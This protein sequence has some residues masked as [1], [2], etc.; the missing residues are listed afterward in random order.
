M[1]ESAILDFK[2]SNTKEPVFEANCI[3]ALVHC[4]VIV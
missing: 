4:L 1:K 2:C 3:I